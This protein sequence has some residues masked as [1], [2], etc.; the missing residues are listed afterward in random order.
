MVIRGTATG[1]TG[2]NIFPADRCT[3]VQ[4]DSGDSVGYRITSARFFPG[5]TAAAGVT[6]SNTN[7]ELGY[8]GKSGRFVP[9]TDRS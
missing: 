3:W 4:A 7:V 2:T 1:F 5:N 6:I 8:I 9:I